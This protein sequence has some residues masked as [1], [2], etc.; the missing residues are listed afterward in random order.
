MERTHVLDAIWRAERRN[1][2]GRPLERAEH[3]G[4][5]A[6]QQAH[7][8]LHIKLEDT[9][10]Q[11]TGDSVRRRG[12][13]EPAKREAI[14]QSLTTS[15]MSQSQIASRFGVSLPTVAKIRKAMRGTGESGV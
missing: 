6:K 14:R 13:I 8:N 2:E 1:Y 11:L 5:Q 15:G 9:C 7:A 4:Y 3:P 10:N 12:M